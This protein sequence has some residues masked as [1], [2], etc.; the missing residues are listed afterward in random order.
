MNNYKVTLYRMVEERLDWAIEADNAEAALAALKEIA[1]A[2]TINRWEGRIIEGSD[3][4][5]VVIAR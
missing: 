2:A 1:E 3:D 5:E 4:F